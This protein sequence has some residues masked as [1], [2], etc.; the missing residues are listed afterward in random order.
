MRKESWTRQALGESIRHIARTGTLDE[1]DEA[2][3][4]M[5][6]KEVILE[7]DV[8][9]AVPIDRVFAHRDTIGIILPDFR[10]C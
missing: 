2:R 6:A 10:R 1:F 4:R 9:R 8:A 7:V 5:L 3:P